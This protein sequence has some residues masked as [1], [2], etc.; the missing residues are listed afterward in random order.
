MH[1]YKSKAEG[2]MKGK[3]RSMGGKMSGKLG[4]LDLSSDPYR[5]SYEGSTDTMQHKD[6]S[7]SPG[8]KRGGRIGM[9]AGADSGEGRLQKARKYPKP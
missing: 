6:Q 3:M 8:Y 1:P 9:T 7:A 2:S 4:N 5:H